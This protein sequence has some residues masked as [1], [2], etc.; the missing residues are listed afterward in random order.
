M[1]SFIFDKNPTGK[2]YYFYLGKYLFTYAIYAVQLHYSYYIQGGAQLDQLQI[3]QLGKEFAKFFVYY[4]EG[5]QYVALIDQFRWAKT[6]TAL[7]ES[8]MELL[9]YSNPDGDLFDSELTDNDWKRLTNF[10]L[11]ADIRKV[12]HLHTTMIRYIS[13]FELEKIK[14]TEEYLTELLIH[15]DEQE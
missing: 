13:A 1:H 2:Y 4:C 9:Q 12:R 10:I 7:I 3:H 5:E 11:Q 15:F 6:R 8:M 14:M